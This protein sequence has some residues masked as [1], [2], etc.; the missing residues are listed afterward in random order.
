MSNEEYRRIVEAVPEGIWVVDP[1]GWTIF[2][3]RRMAE[4]LGV[5]FESMPQQ[6]CFGCV[7]PDELEEAQ[8]HFARTL[9][10]DHR[11]FDFRLRRADGSPIWVS[12]SCMP[13]HDDT[14]APTG[15]LG[16]FSDITDRKQAE[17]ALRESEERFRNMADT[18]PVMIWVSGLDKLCTFFNKRWLAFRGRTLEQ[19]LG[20]GWVEGVHPEDRDRC[21]AIFSS[22]FDSRRPFQKECR[23]RRADG[24]YRWVLDNG[25]PLYR[26]GEF[27]GFI[28]S[29]I[30]ITEQKLIEERLRA[31]EARLTDAQRLAKVGSWERHMEADKIHWSEEMLRILGMPDLPPSSFSEFLNCVHPND[32]EKILEAD[33]RIRSTNGPVEVEYRLISRE[34]E[35]RFARSIAEAIRSDQGAVLR[36]VGATQDVTEQ[37]KADQLLHESEERLK[38]AEHL[39]HVGHWH[40]NLKSGRVTWSDECSRIFGLPLGYAPNQEEFFQ[41]IAPLDREAV[42]QGARHCLEEKGQSS[43]EFRIVRRDGEL[44]TVM[45]VSEVLLDDDGQP[46]S[47][48]GAFQDI[49]DVK[50][51]QE[52]TVARQKLESLGT[53][54]SGI[55]HDFNNL[56]GGT[57]AQAELALEEYQAGPGWAPC[58]ESFVAG[59]RVEAHP[60]WGYPGLRNR[61]P[62]DDLCRKRERCGGVGR[63]LAGG[64]RHGRIAQGL[65]IEA[66][67][68]RNRF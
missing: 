57:L 13:I 28:G 42:A 19:E 16:L 29:S 36:L 44:R 66:R 22:A 7:F 48:F 49:T 30:D 47:V 58:L 26:A 68:F 39:A 24:E 11:P 59:R 35:V 21:S 9:A 3:N 38:S 20:K 40:R 37:V 41:L 8:R 43:V 27:A 32:R 25:I 14:G 31:S 54:A 10:G 65:N 18:A 34:G 5:D 1:Q 33:R 51:A 64:Q 55:A 45:S 61:A 6:S 63:C 53:L 23:L 2:S 50:R 52:E 46:G 4:I 67:G 56:L 17:A 62:I 15:L 12:I 60:G